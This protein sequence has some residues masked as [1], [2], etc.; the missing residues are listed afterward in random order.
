M[1]T[2]PFVP[3]L[4]QHYDLR[5]SD[6]CDGLYILLSAED[7]RKAALGV[8]EDSPER[9]EMGMAARVLR[10][11][12][13]RELYDAALNSGKS[14]RWS[15]LEHLSRHGEW[16]QMQASAGMQGASQSSP[17]AAVKDPTKNE[18]PYAHNPFKPHPQGPVPAVSQQAQMDAVAQ[19]QRV[20]SG[21]RNWMAVGDYFLF[22]MSAGVIAAGLGINETINTVGFWVVYTLVLIAYVVG[23]ETYAGGSPVKLM[24]G[25][26]VQ[27]ATT[28][29]KLSLQQSAKRNWWRL[30]SMVPGIGQLVSFVAAIGYSL[31][32]DEHDGHGKHDRDANAQVVRKPQR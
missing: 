29:K 15:D 5:P 27:D 6:S 9:Q 21:T 1:S 10:Y 30:V 28:G 14:I 11:P 24:A 25:Y 8:P 18:S 4:Y 26:R 22:N 16:P 12:Q 17:Y 20:P 2:L 3:N 13:T 7:S 31:S 32:I 19:P 23:F